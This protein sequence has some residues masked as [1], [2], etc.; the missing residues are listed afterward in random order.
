MSTFGEA[1]AKQDVVAQGSLSAF[2]DPAQ[3]VL[4][5]RSWLSRVY[6][7]ASL[8]ATGVFVLAI[9]DCYIR[10]GVHCHMVS[11]SDHVC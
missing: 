11:M 1:K 9:S 10:C 3:S 5:G 8:L 7:S 2:R 6:S 4:L